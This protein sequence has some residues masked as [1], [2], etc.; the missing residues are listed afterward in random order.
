MAEISL[1]PVD[2]VEILSV[3]DNSVDVLMSSTPTTKRVQRLWDALP[4]LRPFGL[5]PVA[6][7]RRSSK[8]KA[9]ISACRSISLLEL[10]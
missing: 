10:W 3:M 2:R 7:E 6:H 1:K 5:A 4:V 9:E 8:T